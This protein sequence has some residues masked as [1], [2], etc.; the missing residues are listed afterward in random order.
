M[1]L[2][3]PVTTPAAGGWAS[4]TGDYQTCATRTDGTLWC[5]GWNAT[6]QLG[7]GNYTGQDRPRQVIG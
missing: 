1:E 6:G 7:I 5:W 2:P 4:T 3:Q